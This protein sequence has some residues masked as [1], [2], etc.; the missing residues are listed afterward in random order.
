MSRVGHPGLAHPDRVDLDGMVSSLTY[1][2]PAVV[3]LTL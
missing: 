2:G 3:D 1:A